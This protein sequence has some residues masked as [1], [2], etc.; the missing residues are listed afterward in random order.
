MEPTSPLRLP[1]IDLEK[2]G[3]QQQLLAIEAKKL[4]LLEKKVNKA[5]AVDDEDEAFFKSLLPHVRKLK[6]EQKLLFRME[7]QKVVHKFVYP[8][9]DELLTDPNSSPNQNIDPCIDLFRA[10]SSAN[11]QH[12]TP[13]RQPFINTDLR[14]P[15]YH[16]YIS[17]PAE[18][19]AEIAVEQFEGQSICR[20]TIISSARNY[21]TVI[22]S[23]I[24]SV[25]PHN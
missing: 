21:Y 19:E 13:V 24:S 14:T 9:Q 20:S 22:T 23:P 17:P 16:R 25:E 5:A 7:V 10:S 12:S 2:E 15:E 11:T 8:Q 18:R 4:K 1:T 6:S 3:P